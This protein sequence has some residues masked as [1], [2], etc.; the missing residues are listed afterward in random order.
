MVLSF[1]YAPTAGYTGIV[2]DLC[3]P[4]PDIHTSHVGGVVPPIAHT[5]HTTERNHMKVWQVE[6]K[7]AGVA[8][9]KFKTEEEAKSW[10]LATFRPFRLLWE[11]VPA[12]S[13][14]PEGV[15]GGTLYYYYDKVETA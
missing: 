3:I 13:S 5:G 8:P 11:R 1:P 9:Y 10:G 4:T 12:V 7:G 14:H 6:I 2:Q 15:K